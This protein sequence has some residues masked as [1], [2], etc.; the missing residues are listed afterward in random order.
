MKFAISALTF[1]NKKGAFLSNPQENAHEMPFDIEENVSIY[2][3]SGDCFWTSRETT[4]ILRVKRFHEIFQYILKKL[5]QNKP[6]VKSKHMS[7]ALK[8]ILSEA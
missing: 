5:K 2:Y 6:V 7:F 3:I 8:C 1:A 4:D